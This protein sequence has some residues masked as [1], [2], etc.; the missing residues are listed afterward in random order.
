MAITGIN[1]SSCTSYYASGY[2]NTVKKAVCDIQKNKG[3]FTGEQNRRESG[4]LCKKIAEKN[5]QIDIVSGSSD[6]NVKTANR[7]GKTDVRITPEI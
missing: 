2:K 6:K 7:T 5:P 4:R 1:N 3:K